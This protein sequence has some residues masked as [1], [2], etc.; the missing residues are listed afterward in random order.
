MAHALSA[1]ALGPIPGTE[2]TMTTTA[3]TGQRKPGAFAN[4]ARQ[5]DF[6]ADP[7][8]LI[9]SAM[10]L[11]AGAGGA[12]SAWLLLKM[13]AFFTNLAFFGRISTA[14][15]SISGSPLGP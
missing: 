1:G 9:L 3:S 13:I 14:A 12:A 11:V 7:R 10:A 4:A 15:V 5:G 6:T 2:T 8:L